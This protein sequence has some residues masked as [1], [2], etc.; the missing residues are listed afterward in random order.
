MSDRTKS[1]SVRRLAFGVQ[2]TPLKAGCCGGYRR[3]TS[4]N[5]FFIFGGMFVFVTFAY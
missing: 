2:G 5:I 3:A 1:V 4:H